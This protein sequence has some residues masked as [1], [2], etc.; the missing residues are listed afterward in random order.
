MVKLITLFFA[1]ST[2]INSAYA[3]TCENKPALDESYQKSSLIF[4]GQVKAKAIHPL[5]Q[6]KMEFR[7]SVTRKIKGFDEVNGNTVLIYTPRD[8]EYCG[9]RFQEGQDYLVYADGTPANF[10]TTACSKTDILDKSLLDVQKLIR[11]S[12]AGGKG[13]SEPDVPVI[14]QPPPAK[15]SSKSL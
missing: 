14:N 13:N 3:C 15:K 10:N 4:V 7:F 2:G 6:D 12:G 8:H 11:M 5:R 1:I 9:F